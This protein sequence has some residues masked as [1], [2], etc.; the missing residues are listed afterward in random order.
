[1]I[2]AIEHADNST[3]LLSATPAMP[4]RQNTDDSVKRRDD[5][6]STT[7]LH[8]IPSGSDT[9]DAALEHYVCNL[10]LSSQTS[11][12]PADEN[13][14][15][16]PEDSSLNPDYA[17]SAPSQASRPPNPWLARPQ[18]QPGAASRHNTSSTLSSSGAMRLPQ[19]SIPIFA[20]SANLEKHSQESLEAAGFDGWLHKPIDYRRLVLVLKGA[21]CE[22][23]RALGRYSSKEPKLGGWFR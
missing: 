23:S 8:I 15:L 13:D 12:S 5:S 16:P 4:S 10:P 19:R 14:L 11:P 3:P 17:M 22:E 7:S 1:M 21:F 20:V 2:R 18:R 9:S 6:A